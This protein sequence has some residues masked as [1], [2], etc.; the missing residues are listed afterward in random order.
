MAAR[1]IWTARQH[2]A[3]GGL[4]DMR[5][6]WA[7]LRA[8]HRLRRHGAGDE[9]TASAGASACGAESTAPARLQRRVC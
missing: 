6:R 7:L 5:P 3:V 2:S 8:G 1:S 9:H 4:A